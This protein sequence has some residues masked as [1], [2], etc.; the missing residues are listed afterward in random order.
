MA[1]F[2]IGVQKPNNAPIQSVNVWVDKRKYNEFN[3]VLN[4]II[5]LY[6]FINYVHSNLGYIPIIVQNV[7]LKYS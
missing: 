5:T 3:I 2:K 4:K 7:L 1:T 6:L